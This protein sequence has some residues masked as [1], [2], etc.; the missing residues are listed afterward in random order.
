MRAL[1]LKTQR[2]TPLVTERENGLYLTESLVELQREHVGDGVRR[3]DVG[4][5]I[6]SEDGPDVRQAFL[7]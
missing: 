1:L 3:L 6:A 4:L 5:R 7:R 2:A